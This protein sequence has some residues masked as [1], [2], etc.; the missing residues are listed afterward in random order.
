MMTASS[1]GLSGA[2]LFVLLW[3]RP[4]A[5]SDT[6]RAIRRVLRS[7]IAVMSGYF[8]QIGESGVCSHETV[9][10]LRPS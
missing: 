4:A 8:E 5:S 10:E 6:P 7:A 3:L 9:L 1:S 2:G